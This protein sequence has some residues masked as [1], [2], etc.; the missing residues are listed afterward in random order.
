MNRNTGI[1]Q[2]E[3]WIGSSRLI[4]PADV[5]QN[6]APRADA[7][8]PASAWRPRTPVQVQPVQDKPSRPGRPT[9]TE[10]PSGR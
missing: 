8:Q 3:L 4:A 9:A 5:P 1:P 6:G 7:G 2:A 10:R